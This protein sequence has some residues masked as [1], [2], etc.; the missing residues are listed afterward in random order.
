MGPLPLKSV[1]GQRRHFTFLRALYRANSSVLGLAQNFGKHH[2][3][4]RI[5][6]LCEISRVFR[7]YMNMLGLVLHPSKVM[8]LKLSGSRKI[9]WEKIRIFNF[10]SG[11][12]NFA[13][14]FWPTLAANQQKQRSHCRKPLAWRFQNSFHMP[15]STL[16]AKDMPQTRGPRAKTRLHHF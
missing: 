6:V 2:H 5:G 9:K 8:W 14:I 16:E 12:P 4:D 1:Q 7:I 15:Q 13:P 11:T 10:F 3:K